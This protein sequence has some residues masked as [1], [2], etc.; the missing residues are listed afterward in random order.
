ME[1]DKLQCPIC[2]QFIPFS[3]AQEHVDGCLGQE[4]NEKR[5]KQ[6]AEDERLAR[7]FVEAFDAGATCEPSRSITRTRID[8]HIFLLTLAFI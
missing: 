7:Q 4:E 8:I 6:E 5:K 1:E 2:D 3:V